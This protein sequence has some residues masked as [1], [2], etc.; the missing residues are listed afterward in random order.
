M[1]HEYKTALITGASGGMGAAFARQLGADGCALVLVARKTGQLR[2]L[3]DELQAAYGTQ[4]EVLQAD[5]TDPG[6]ALAVEQ[7]LADESRPVDLL[8]N[9]AGV[10]GRIGALSDQSP[11]T[12]AHKIDLNV[13]VPVKLT[14]AALPGMLGRGKG[15]IVN[16]SSVAAFVPTPNA[17]TYSATKSFILS[18][19]E[20]LHGET[21]RGGVHVS[22]LCPGSMRTGIHDAD[23][24]RPTARTPARLGVLDPEVVARAAID[25][26]AAGKPVLVPGL[27]WAA[28]AALS[29]K[30]P[31]SLVR[32]LFYRLWGR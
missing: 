6:Q 15:G 24:G 13:V 26:V 28:V 7:R 2:E 25:A 12:Q 11:D 19:S 3:A 21:R 31:R 18:F 23:P 30:L 5:L 8:V 32:H 22:V 4:T 27:R 14:R 10:F 17:A 1:R 20:S 9:C 29:R 16:V